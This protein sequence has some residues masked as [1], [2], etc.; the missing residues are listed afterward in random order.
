M[1]CNECLSLDRMFLESLVSADRASTS[2][3]CFFLTH[4]RSAGVSDLE[5][6]ESLRRHEQKAADERH[7]AYMALIGHKK[8]HA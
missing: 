5:E 3:R 6:Y 8:A 1:D 4:Q 2:L 7:R